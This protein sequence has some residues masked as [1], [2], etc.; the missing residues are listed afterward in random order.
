MSKLVSKITLGAYRLFGSAIYPFMG[1]FL[2]LRAKRGKEERRRRYE[3]YGYS[4]E[5]KPEGPLVWFHAAS[6]GEAMAVLALVERV[7]ALGIHAV[8]T[9]GTVTS[10]E[11]VR[12]R[13]PKSAYHQYVPLDLKPAVTRFLDHWKPDLAV[14]TESEIWPT[15]IQKLKKEKIP[16]VLVNARMSDRSFKRWQSANN[17]AEELFDCFSHV[18]AQSEVDAQRFRDLGARPVTCTGNLKVDTKSLPVNDVE[19]ASLVKQSVGRPTWV[20]ASTHKGE[21]EIILR[22][23]KELKK[24]FPTLL[25]VLV[26]R[27]PNRREEIVHLLHNARLKFSQRSKGEN[28]SPDCDVYLGDTIGE[29]GLY[30]RM[31]PIIFMGRSLSVFGGQ[32]A[33]EPAAIGAAIISGNNVTNFR[34]V[35]KNLLENDGVRLVKNGKMLQSNLSFL[36]KNP[37]ECAKMIIGGKKTVDEMS[38]ALENTV[39]VLDSYVFPL[40]VKSK[41]EAL[42]K[43]QP[44]VTK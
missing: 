15:T 29:M 44:T 19:L 26:P 27:H 35:Y 2:H 8:L 22:T 11:L 40:T 32:N 33:L 31:A 39:E 17:V 34:D 10:A 3:R 9:T 43:R 18:A 20:A 36:L 7:H 37:S 42:N 5:D 16:Q 41:L 25:T 1:P 14:F 38:G 21:E 28:I 23:H 4:S 12:E 24:E 30:I 13:L 6:V